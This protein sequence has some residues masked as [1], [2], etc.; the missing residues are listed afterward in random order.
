MERA[1][2]KACG[3]RRTG[4]LNPSGKEVGIFKQRREDKVGE[5]GNVAGTRMD[6]VVWDM[7]GQMQFMF[8]CKIDENTWKEF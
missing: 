1:E 6:S 5:E 3:A 4:S 2:R 7:A 8:F